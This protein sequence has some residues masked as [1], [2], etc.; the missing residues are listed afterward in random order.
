MVSQNGSMRVRVVVAVIACLAAAGVSGCGH[1]VSCDVAD[2]G[3]GGASGYQTPQQALNSALAQR[4]QWL[5]ATGWVLKEKTA[6]AATFTSGD[7]TVDVVKTAAGTWI[8][9][10]VTACH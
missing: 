2:Y 4:M 6:H 3:A 9:G 1:D 5:S 10:G 8:V 7:D